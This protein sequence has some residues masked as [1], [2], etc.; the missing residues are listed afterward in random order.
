[1]AALSPVYLALL[2][3]QLRSEVKLSSVLGAGL[4]NRPDAS[5]DARP[6]RARRKPDRSKVKAAR[7]QRRRQKGSA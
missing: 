5:G 6:V 1:M 3:A 4:T 7:V 2:A